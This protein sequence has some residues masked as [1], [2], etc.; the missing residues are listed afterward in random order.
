[1]EE[2]VMNLKGGVQEEL[3]RGRRGGGNDAIHYS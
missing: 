1:M 3:E 2:E